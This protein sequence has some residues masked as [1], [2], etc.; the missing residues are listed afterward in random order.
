MDFAN[1]LGSGVRARRPKM[2]LELFE[3]CFRE[4][5]LLNIR[6]MEE[7]RERSRLAAVAPGVLG[8]VSVGV[9]T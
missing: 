5:C 4:A 7:F 2:L 8:V 3:L 6:N 9:Q 1:P